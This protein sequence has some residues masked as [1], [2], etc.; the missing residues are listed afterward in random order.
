LSRNLKKLDFD[1][2]NPIEALA[3]LHVTNKGHFQNLETL[4][5]H[6]KSHINTLEF[7]L[8]S[9]LTD[10]EMFGE[11]EEGEMELSLPLSS[12]PPCLTR[13][14]RKL[15]RFEFSGDAKFPC[16]SSP[17]AWNT[18]LSFLTKMIPLMRLIGMH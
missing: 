6:S 16:I 11:G 13:L 10:L 5:I 1:C 15:K 17:S 18:S 14:S 7:D 8:P 4:R 2:P 12:L 9:T 3:Q